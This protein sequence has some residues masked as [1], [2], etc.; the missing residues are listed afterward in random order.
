MAVSNGQPGNQTSFNNAF[1]SRTQDS[2]TIGRVDLANSATGSGGSITN[3]QRELN[4]LN[5]FVGSIPNTPVDSDPVLTNNEVGSIGDSLAVR[6]DALSQ[7]FN[8]TGGH[9]HS[10]SAGDGAPIQG[11]FIQGVPLEGWFNQGVDIELS[12]T[13]IDVSTELT[14]KSPSNSDTVI[15][16]V[17]NTPYNKVILRQASGPNLSSAF[18]DA[19]GDEIYGR[20][21]EAAGVWTLSFFSEVAGVETAHDFTSPVDARWFY[22]ELYNPLVASPVY[23]PAAFIPSD[24]ATADVLD[25]S[26]IQRGLVSTGAQTFAGAK[27][28]NGAVTFNNDAIVS[29]NFDSF[30]KTNTAGVIT[31]VTGDKGS[32]IVHN[33]TTPVEQPVGADGFVLT[34]DAAEPT[35]VKWAVATS[36]PDASVVT[37]T[38]AGDISSTTVQA[39][40]EELDSEKARIQLSNL[41]TTAINASL[42]PDT[43]AAYDLGT[44]NESWRDIYASRYKNNPNA[45]SFTGDT[46]TG[47]PTITAIPSTSLLETYHGVSGAGIPS[48]SWIV[49]KT[50]NSVT[51]NQNAT[52]TAGSVSF[53]ALGQAYLQTPAESLTNISAA[54]VVETGRTVDGNSGTA[55]VQTG[56]SSGSGSSGDIILRTGSVVS[57]AR[58]RALIDASFVAIPQRTADPSENRAGGL[59]WNTTDQVFR[60]NDGTTWDDLAGGGSG[61][62]GINYI[63]NFD[64]EKDTAGWLTYA[65]ASQAQPV[66]GVGGSPTVTWTRTTTSPLRGDGSFLFTKDNA[67]RRGQGVAYAFAIDL[68]DRAKMMQISGDY[69]R[70]SGTYVTGDLTAYIVDVTNGTVIQPAAFQIENV[71]ISSQF[72]MTF[73]TAS[74]SVSY[75]L[76]FHVASNSALDYSLKFDNIRLG[77]QV[78]PLGAPVTDWVAYTPTGSNTGTRVGR[79]RRVGDSMEIESSFIY[80]SGSAQIDLDLPA[81]HS[82]DAAKLTQPNTNGESSILG[83]AKAFDLSASTPRIGSIIYNNPTRVRVFDTT[84]SNLWNAGANLPWVWASGDSANFNFK[85]PIAGWSSSTVVSSS[86][87]TRVVAMRASLTTPQVGITD[88]V[89]PFNSAT[90]DT[91][92]GLNVSTGVYTVSVPGIY[93][94]TARITSFDMDT[95]NSSTVELRKNNV[96]FGRSYTAILPGAATFQYGEIQDIVPCVAGD[97]LSIFF[98]GDA[99]FGLDNNNSRTAF[100]VNLISG[101]SQIAASEVIECSYTSDTSLAL[102]ATVPATK[103]YEDRISDTHGAYNTSTG[104]FTAPAPGHYVV[105]ASAVGGVPSYAANDE[106]AIIF[107]KN[108]VEIYRDRIFCHAA[109]SIRL[110]INGSHSVYLNAGETLRI[111]LVSD[112][113]QNTLTSAS[114]NTLHIYR[115]GGIG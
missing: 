84:A 54:A 39:A 106:F 38:P 8:L 101:P 15:G 34:A 65:D 20:V 96:A 18:V 3:A 72:T 89:I 99:S 68:A 35:G 48:G 60:Q 62:G 95:T 36:S 52:A 104:V 75:R 70:V 7:R 88:K 43:D 41:G 51:L 114:S 92:A 87:D 98:D 94:V 30:L 21:T 111:Q 82:I 22:Q 5:N 42:N 49:S 74:N 14:G 37:V 110:T 83:V 73:Q 67:D 17:V 55:T 19:D 28:F 27:G 69:E 25:A 97:T 77:P 115:L 93:F 16:V 107:Q 53:L 64:A 112:K 56:N 100:T 58:G 80:T 33:G 63:E 86:A 26:A 23:D 81:G 61:V 109:G 10:G 71:G 6:A 11:S 12:G 79:Y 91:H 90:V 4:K 40:L 108:S 57:G 113:S 2:D 1:V 47:S 66:D 24:S 59:Y 102:T 44:N 105:S 78:V 29:T 13:S 85:V 76:C 45:A 9:A 46:T 31:G 50:A 103:I 32:I